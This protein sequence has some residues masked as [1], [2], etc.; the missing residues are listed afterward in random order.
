[1]VAAL[2]EKFG[3]KKRAPKFEDEGPPSSSDES[4]GAGGSSKSSSKDSSP[5]EP[6]MEMGAGEPDGD[7]TMGDDPMAGGDPEEQAADDLADILGVGPDD[8]EDFGNALQAY[9][10]ACLAKNMA[11][12]P[13]MGMPDMGGGPEAGGAPPSGY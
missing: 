10:S 9:V 8:R 3:G 4:R 2:T 13:D 11:P 7:E 1:M 5:P 6:D 12:A